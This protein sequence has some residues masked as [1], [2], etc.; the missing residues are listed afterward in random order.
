VPV[1]ERI[2]D[3]TIALVERSGFK[4]VNMMAVAREA[5]VSRQT[6]YAHFDSR[7]D[8]LSKAMIR[9]VTQVNDRVNAEIAGAS[10]ASEYVV[11]FAVAMRSE[12][13]RHR[14]L[15]L[16]LFP[17]GGSPLFDDQVIARA[18][19]VG[20]QFLEPLLRLEPRLADRFD[21]VVE[22]TLR[23]GLS[24]FLFDSDAIHT[25]DDLRT[26]LRKSLVPALML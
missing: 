5:G 2:L 22:I 10:S 26:F 13:R 6:V 21:D 3:A 1:R 14:L 24:V 15:G 16:L 25:D 19:P 12:F 8:L 17:D 18:L 11:E 9:V 4:A 20:A 7:E 23:F